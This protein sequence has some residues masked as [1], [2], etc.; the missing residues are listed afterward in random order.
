MAI[1]NL[2][3]VFPIFL[4]GDA[5]AVAAAGSWNGLTSRIDMNGAFTL[6]V[7]SGV[8]VPNGTLVFVKNDTGGALTLT[9]SPDPFG[10]VE[11]DEI[12]LADNNTVSLMYV[13]AT[14]GFHPIGAV[15][16]S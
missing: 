8:D 12:A 16:A 9:V 5:Q 11:L 13:N 3:R 14:I 10:D 7:P 6:S 1:K 4:D 2:N 15:A